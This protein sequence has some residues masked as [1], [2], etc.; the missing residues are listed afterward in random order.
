[1][2]TDTITEIG[3]SDDR[4]F[5]GNYTYGAPVYHLSEKNPVEALNPGD[6]VT[7][8]MSSITK[9]YYNFIVELMDET[10]E[11]RNPLFSGPPANI[12]TNISND[13][14]GFF[15]AYSTTYSTTIY[16]SR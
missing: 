15:A 9:E 13:G 5:N 11:F 14:V 10:F 3:I 1:M 6:T 8:M 2:I 12:S 4:F 7:L 16:N